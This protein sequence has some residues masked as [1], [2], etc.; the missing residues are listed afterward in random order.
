MTDVPRLMP[1]GALLCI[2]YGLCHTMV[3]AGLHFLCVWWARCKILFH[4]REPKG[5]HDSQK[6]FFP[7]ELR[8]G[9]TDPLARDHH[10]V[11]ICTNR[12]PLEEPPQTNLTTMP[13][14]L[15]NSLRKSAMYGLKRSSPSSSSSS[16]WSV[17]SSASPSTVSWSSTASRPTSTFA[18][19]SLSLP[20]RDSMNG[21][22]WGSEVPPQ[23]GDGWGHFVD[24]DNTL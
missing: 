23:G 6:T 12:K 9:N 4:Q 14:I 18:P 10:K 15:N 7:P 11:H 20:K 16:R 24:C 22:M 13:G 8:R 1:Q 21:S 17:S 5:G 3:S 19:N 2:E